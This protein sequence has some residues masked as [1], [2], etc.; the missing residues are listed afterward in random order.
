[1]EVFATYTAITV[2]DFTDMRVR[3]FAGETDRVYAPHMGEH[4]TEVL[5][6]GFDFYEAYKVHAFGPENRA[7][8]LKEYGMV[9]EDV[10]RPTPVP[11]AVEEFEKQNP[12][13]WGFIP[14]KGWIQSVEHFAQCLLEGT[15]PMNA[16]GRAGAL[17][18]RI[19]LALLESLETGQAVRM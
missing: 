16:D 5:K 8:Y 7:S 19:A 17:S 1:M 13:L 12:E 15:E 18:T 9:V 3:G 6:Y 2:S 4:A 11:F 10:V 14:D